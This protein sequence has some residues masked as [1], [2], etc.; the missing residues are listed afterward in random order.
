MVGIDDIVITG[1]GAV[2]PIGIGRT[3]LEQSLLAGRCNSKVLNDCGELSAE[4]IGAPI[5]NYDGKD[6]IAPRKALKMM[7]RELQISHT[8]AQLA[9]EDANLQDHQCDC[10]RVGVVFGSE[11]IPG[12]IADLQSCIRACS[13]GPNID[14]DRWGTQFGKEIFPL[15]MLRYL[16]N[17]PA[18]HVAI[19]VNARGPNN[20]LLVE[21][22]SGLLALAE[23]ISIMERGQTDIML[24]GAVGNRVTPTRLLYRRKRYYFDSARPDAPDRFH[25]RAFDQQRSGIVPSEAAVTLI[26]ERRRHAVARGATVYGHVKSTVSRF[27]K[28]LSPSAGSTIAIQNAAL[29]AL[30]QADISA[31]DLACISAQGFSEANLDVVEANAIASVAP[32]TPVTAYSSYLGTAGAGSGLAQLATA[33]IATGSGLVL[34]TLGYSQ[35]DSRCPIRPCSQKQAT[36]ARHLLQL[37]FTFE[38]QA[39]AV[40]VDC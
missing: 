17:M 8:S 26:L 28:P 25:S 40:V 32:D 10:D 30:E 13:T 19:A 3:A 12:D 16:P 34:P 7:G 36:T 2:T 37:S 24:V 21:E 35:P 27:G 15:W 38:G 4:L 39:A 5:E 31:G 29:A 11:M 20:T 1:I 18:C 9:W 23:A 33:M 6:Y 14:H 22:T